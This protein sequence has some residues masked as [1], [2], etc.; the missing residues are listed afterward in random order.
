MFSEIVKGLKFMF[1]PA[2]VAKK[3]CKN[4]HE[5]FG[6]TIT[7]GVSALLSFVVPYQKYII[8]DVTGVSAVAWFLISTLIYMVILGFVLTFLIKAGI[9]IINGRNSCISRGGVRFM[10]TSSLL[11]CALILFFSAFFTAG[12]LAVDY[13]VRDISGF[14]RMNLG[15]H[16]VVCIWSL[17]IFTVGLAECMSMLKAF[18]IAFLSLSVTIALSASVFAVVETRY[19][20][21]SAVVDELMHSRD[22]QASSVKNKSVSEHTASYDTSESKTISI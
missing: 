19:S 1:K 3:E 5:Q 12:V 14:L 2:T 18:I 20:F 9:E 4:A 21:A 8:E 13:W 15:I 6:W 11:P 7:A 22:D 16:A 17:V 10:L